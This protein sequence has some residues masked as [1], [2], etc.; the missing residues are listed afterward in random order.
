MPRATR[1]E[2]SAFLLAWLLALLA[3]AVDAIGF[4]RL[5]HLF[6][7]FMG[8]NTTTLSV[9]AAQGHWPEA[10]QGGALVG[11]FVAGAAIGGA[12][13]R[14]AG[15]RHLPVVLLIVALLLAAGGAGWAPIPLLTLAM[16]ALNATLHKAGP[17][18]FGVTYVTGV[19]GRFGEGL[20]RSVADLMAGRRPGWTWIGQGVLWGGLVVGVAAGTGLVTLLDRQAAFVPAGFALVLAGAA[21]RPAAESGAA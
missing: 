16:G 11:F 20:G 10:W 8:G 4:I 13:E 14:V 6:V 9:A 12:T 21:L 2:G 19:L 15:Q 1:L 5:G 18:P 7:A 3:G 17:V